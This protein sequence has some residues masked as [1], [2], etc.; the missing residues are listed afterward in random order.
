L[1]AQRLRLRLLLPLLVRVTPAIAAAAT[2]V[3]VDG[4]VGAPLSFPLLQHLL[5][6]VR[7][8]SL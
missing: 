1:L 6:C 8:P 7:P 5:P 4:V 3:V 2:A